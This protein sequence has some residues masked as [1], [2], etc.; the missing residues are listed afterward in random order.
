MGDGVNKRKEKRSGVG[1]TA[2]MHLLRDPNWAPKCREHWAD[3]PL[4]KLNIPVI[5]L[6]VFICFVKTF[7]HKTQ[8]TVNFSPAQ[9]R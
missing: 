1:C 4:S 3:R 7:L 6:S 9:P 2:D 8:A 5:L